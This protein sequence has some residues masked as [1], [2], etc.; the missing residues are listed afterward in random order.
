MTAYRY[1]ADTLEVTLNGEPL[2]TDSINV[3]DSAWTIGQSLFVGGVVASKGSAVVIAHGESDAPVTTTVL[4]V[5]RE[6]GYVRGPSLYVDDGSPTALRHSRDIFAFLD[7]LVG[8]AGRGRRRRQRAYARGVAFVGARGFAPYCCVA[9]YEAR[10]RL[11][12]RVFAQPVEHNPL[13][14]D[15]S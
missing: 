8:P 13:A 6:L 9:C 3:T 2:A 10:E 11:L 14:R 5:H 15:E 4:Y 1:R 7:T 12:T